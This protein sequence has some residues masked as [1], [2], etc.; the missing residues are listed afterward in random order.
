MIIEYSVHGCTEPSNVQRLP[1]HDPIAT[2]PLTV[3][4]SQSGTTGRYDDRTV[5]V[6]GSSTLPPPRRA[7]ATPCQ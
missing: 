6:N 5:R 4:D 7:A 3:T 1:C 2:V